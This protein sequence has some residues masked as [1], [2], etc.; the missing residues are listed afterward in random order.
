MKN[1]QV[2]RKTQE[3]VNKKGDFADKVNL[4]N[5]IKSKGLYT[6]TK[7]YKPKYYK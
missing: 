7:V 2:L 1:E 3:I 5:K 4:S 6:H